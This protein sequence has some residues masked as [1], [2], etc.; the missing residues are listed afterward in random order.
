MDAEGGQGDCLGT[1]LGAWAVREGWELGET[2]DHHVQKM[3]GFASVWGRRVHPSCTGS[4]RRDESFMVARA[5]DSVF[6]LLPA[7]LL[8]SL[9][10]GSCRGSSWSSQKSL[11]FWLIGSRAGKDGPLAHS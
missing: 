9:L 6:L 7:L 3:R 4:G 11:W 5:L 1:H 10:L 8:V 2:L